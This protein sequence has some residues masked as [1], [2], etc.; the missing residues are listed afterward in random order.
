MKETTEKVYRCDHCGKRYARKHACLKHEACC[1]KAPHNLGVCFYCEHLDKKEIEYYVEVMAAGSDLGVCFRDDKRKSSCYYCKLLDKKMYPT[2]LDE[3]VDKYPENFED[4][5]RM[6][7][8][9]NDKKE[10]YPTF[11]P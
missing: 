9:C 5:E 1:I 2:S 3:I 6:P 10:G 11:Y 4:Q 8:E 7:T